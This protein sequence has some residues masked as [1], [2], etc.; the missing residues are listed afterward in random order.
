VKRETPEWFKEA[1]E[2]HDGLGGFEKFVFWWLASVAVIVVLGLIWVGI[3][4]PV[5]GFIVLV[6]LAVLVTLGCLA[7]V[8][9]EW[10]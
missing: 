2:W 4:W 6:V 1:T 8:M 9:D 10:L 7:Y 5:A 3:T